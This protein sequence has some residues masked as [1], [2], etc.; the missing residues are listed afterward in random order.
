MTLYSGPLS[1]FTAKVRI[2]L[3]EKEIH[4]DTVSVPFSRAAGYTPKHPEVLARNPKAQVPV[5]VD[6]DLSLYDSTIIL[7]YLED[8]HP[9]PALYPREPRERARCRQ[10][11]AAADE[12]FFPPVWTLIWETFYQPDPARAD[13]ARVDGARRELAH[14]YR[15]LDARLADREYL[16]HDF[17]VA[18]IGTFLVLSFAVTLGAPPDPALRHLAAWQERVAAR[19]SVAREMADMTAAAAL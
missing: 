14:Y 11:E 1:L 16:C 13:A 5:L 3:R 12:I 6:G 18:D 8:S 2:A 7:E 10:L 17:S 4:A 19:P 9:E 15:E